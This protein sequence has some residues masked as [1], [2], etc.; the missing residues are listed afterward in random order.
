[1]RPHMEEPKDLTEQPRFRDR[2][3]QIITIT[4]TDRSRKGGGM[5]Q[6]YVEELNR[7]SAD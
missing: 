2:K 3:S 6:A 1:M 7:L 4:M 5:S